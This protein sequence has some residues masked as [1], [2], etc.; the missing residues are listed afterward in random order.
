MKNANHVMSLLAG[1]GLAVLILG[2]SNCTSSTAAT[3]HSFD[4]Q[5]GQTLLV[6]Q[7]AL[8]QAKVEVSTLPVGGQK[9][10]ATH[11]LNLAIKHYNQAYDAFVAVHAAV[12]IGAPMDTESL[13]QDIV[14]LIGEIA[15]L[16]D[17]LGH[18]GGT[19][20]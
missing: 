17:A 16:R 12:G 4:M 18:K 2:A 20:Q 8:E 5:A 13:K 11:D 9:Q 3:A 10:V 6:A 15:K 1:L 7:A 19:V 14:T